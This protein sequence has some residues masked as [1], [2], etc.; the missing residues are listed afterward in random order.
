MA[1]TPPTAPAPAPVT[2]PESPAAAVVAAS[3]GAL[4]PQLT[5]AQIAQLAPLGIERTVKAG[6][7]AQ[8]AGE[9]HPR[10]FIVLEGQLEAV[11]PCEK[12]QGPFARFE[13]GM[14]TGEQTLL[15]G[16][17]GLIAIRAAV[18]T[19]FIAIDREPL[20]NIVQTDPDLSNVFMRAFMMR[21]LA[22]IAQSVSDV[23]LIG[24]DHSAGTLRAKEFLTRNGHPFMYVDLDRDEGVQDLIDRFA[25]SVT[26]VPVLICR[27]ERVLRDPSNAEIADCLGFNAAVDATLMRDV[28]VIGA[29]PSGLAAA[30]YAASEG[31]DVL[32]IESTAPGGQAGS[33][34]RI[35][36]YLGFPMGVSGQELAAR[37]ITQAQKFGAN[38]MIARDAKELACKKRPYSLRLEDGTIVPARTII[39]AT[40]AQYRKLAL[41]NLAQFEGNGIYYGATFVEAQVCRGDEVVVVGGANSAGQ[42]A[43]YLAQWTKHVHMLVRSAGL[44]ETMSRYLELRIEQSPNITLH[45]QTEITRLE[46]DGR[47]ERVTWRDKSTGVE[48]TQDIRHV[49]V[50][51][52]AVPNTNWL[53]G[54]VALDAN[55]FVKTGAD[56][57]EEDLATG[58]WPLPRPPFLL[59]TT[60]PGVFAVG[61][62]RSGNLKR[63]APAVGEGSIAVAFVH[64]VLRG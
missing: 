27:G 45:T 1:M 42:A 52:G 63:V 59:E 43:V 49:F 5:A 26:D 20:M 40:G 10:V 15:S 48:E 3:P 12:G 57:T 54:C 14:F 16:R 36:N 32:V 28:V 18:D 41:P 25:F 11:R 39:I 60:L 17:R 38:L 31:L 29:G 55:G 37:A 22:M 7:I 19:R 35:E 56:L 4:F 6:E 23:V 53:D 34:S 21:R 2:S 64:Q 8:E 62:V 61:D 47:L 13:P 33:S 46:G 30:V 9:P 51:A 24:S 58:E 50:M 44:R